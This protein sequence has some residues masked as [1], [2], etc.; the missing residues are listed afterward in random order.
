MRRFAAI[1]YDL[2]LVLALFMTL[3]FSVILLRA[4]DAV[5][6]GSVWFQLLLILTWWLYFG[7]S[8]THGGQTI[9]MRAWR[10]RLCSRD[11]SQIDWRAAGLRFV[12]ALISSLALGLGFLWCLFDREGLTWHDRLSHTELQ[13]RP[14]ASATERQPA[15]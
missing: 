1:C 13:F 5:A 14:K 7:W 12:G 3:A 15:P 6:S 8:W 11:G 2:L 4:G 10:M 9:G